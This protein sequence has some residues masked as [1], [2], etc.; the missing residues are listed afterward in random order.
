MF[1]CSKALKYVRLKDIIKRVLRHQGRQI[2]ATRCDKSSVKE[3]LLFSLNFDNCK[4]LLAV[5]K[6]LWRQDSDNF[7]IQ[8]TMECNF[9]LGNYSEKLLLLGT[10]TVKWNKFLVHIFVKLLPRKPRIIGS[11]DD[12]FVWA[13]FVKSTVT[14]A[15]R[16]NEQVKVINIISFMFF[17]DKI[18]D[19][20]TN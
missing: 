19:L 15:V 7:K 18:G 12:N 14:K 8:L 5:I 6:S 3:K 9:L 16:M 4:R 2:C 1:H 17:G 10:R 20:D 11:L 13:V